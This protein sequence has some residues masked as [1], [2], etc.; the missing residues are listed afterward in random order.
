MELIMEKTRVCS[1]CGQTKTLDRFYLPERRVRKDGTHYERPRKVC[2]DCANARRRQRALDPER[3]KANAS[4]YHIMKEKDPEKWEYLW[5]KTAR[6]RKFGLT[7]KELDDLKKKANGLCQ[8]C[9]RETELVMD[10]D[11]KTGRL[12]GLICGPC[13]SGLGLLGDQISTLFRAIG[14]LHD[15]AGPP[16]PPKQRRNRRKLPPLTELRQ[17]YERRRKAGHE[18]E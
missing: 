9:M 4:Y 18:R 7:P 10:H 14:Y 16:V 2:R 3:R 6:I 12:R 11:H 8:I 5:G 15:Y 13:N 17:A 1:K